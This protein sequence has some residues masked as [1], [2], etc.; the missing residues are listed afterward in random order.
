MRVIA[1]DS[2]ANGGICVWDTD[3][4]TFVLEK[5]TGDT[6]ETLAPVM[7]RHFDRTDDIKDVVIERPPSFMGPMIP[8]SRIAVLFEAFGITLGY[9][10]A[11]G[12]KPVEVTPQVWQK[13]IRDEKGIKRGE[14]PHGE[15][16]KMLT[17]YAREHYGERKDLINQ[18]AD[19]LLISDWYFQ[20]YNPLL[21]K[22]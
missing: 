19:A 2:G 14:M 18:T 7:A 21:R 6:M 1:I 13:H 12:I 10:A 5:L 4:G 16:K 8:A 9:L 20:V 15:W 22:V 17:E 3:K 11:K